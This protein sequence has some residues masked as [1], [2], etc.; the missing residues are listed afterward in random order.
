MPLNVLIKYDG[1]DVSNEDVRIVVGEDEEW[2]RDL[3][4]VKQGT[5]N[6][7]HNRGKEKKNWGPQ[8]LLETMKTARG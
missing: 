2:G 1:F 3:C 8:P 4:F 5:Q 7:G 6:R